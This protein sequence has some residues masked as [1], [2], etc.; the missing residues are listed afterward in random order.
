MSTRDI[1]SGIAN[2]VTSTNP[3]SCRQKIIELAICDRNCR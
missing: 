2:E 3:N 1:D